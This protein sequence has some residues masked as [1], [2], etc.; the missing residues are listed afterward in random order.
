MLFSCESDDDDNDLACREFN[1]KYARLYELAINNANQTR[2]LRIEESEDRPEG[3]PNN[4]FLEVSAE[5]IEFEEKWDAIWKTW[6]DDGS[7][8]DTGR[9]LAIDEAAEKKELGCY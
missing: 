3:C 2:L 6:K 7:D 9:A 8:G 1:S 5:C 4:I